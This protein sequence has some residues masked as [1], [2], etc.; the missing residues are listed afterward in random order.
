M[1]LISIP[2]IMLLLSLNF[3]TIQCKKN[4]PPKKIVIVIP[5]YNNPLEFTRECLQS[6]LTQEYS[7]FEI[8]FS[9]D[10]S[11]QPNIEEIHK[12]LIMELDID[13]KITYRRNDQRLGPLGNRWNA[14]HTIN[15]DNIEDNRNIIVVNLD[16]DD[17]FYVLMHLL[18]LMIFMK[19]HGQHGAAIAYYQRVMRIAHA[20]R[21]LQ[22]L[23]LKI[24]GA[25]V[26]LA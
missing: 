3:I 7:N 24:N 18:S 25:L 12:K 19:M 20:N 8:V 14:I 23:S 5:S 21:Y 1:K 15:P 26:P 16:G 2:L 6:A 11:P 22:L 17:F 10:C 4:I 13:H 9:D